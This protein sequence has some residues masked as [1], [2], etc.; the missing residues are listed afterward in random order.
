MYIYCKDIKTFSP[1]K[2]FRAFGRV[3]ARVGL[4]NGLERQIKVKDTIRLCKWQDECTGACV[5]S[6]TFTVKP[7]HVQTMTER[8]AL[9]RERDGELRLQQAP[10]RRFR[11]QG[12]SRHWEYQ[13]LL[14][15]PQKHTS[16]HTNTCTHL[17]MSSIVHP[18]KAFN[19]S[20]TF[21][22]CHVFLHH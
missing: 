1:L 4:L 20:S 16:V 21:C 10:T 18:F 6:I 8:L 22:F 11:P 9:E 2:F 7:G 13:T 3:H 19:F 15:P 12:S 14:L 17:L 5:N